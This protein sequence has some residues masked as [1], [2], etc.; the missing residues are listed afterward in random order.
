M[1][2]QIF[3]SYRR[4]G[5]DSI[6]FLLKEHLQ[7]AGYSVFIDLESLRSG[8]FDEKLFNMIEECSVVL[9]VLS[10]NVFERCDDPDDWVRK[11]IAYAIKKKKC[12]IPVMWSDEFEWPPSLPG[13]IKDVTSYNGLPVN[14]IYFDGFIEK[15]CK[16]IDS[17]EIFPTEQI[18]KLKHIVIWAD[19]EENYLHK[20]IKRMDLHE[21]Y[22]VD[23]VNEPAYLLSQNSF[24]IDSIVLIDT[25]VTKLANTD[26]MI[27]RINKYLENYVYCG[28]KLIVTHDVI[29]RRTRNIK[30]QE[31][32]YCR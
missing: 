32:N 4:S 16:M 25:D 2:Y 21:E 26:A 30:L 15:L 31:M 27:N 8:K 9:L 22:F 17:V 20:I 19:F 24:L 1:K 29:Y 23:V 6:A 11:E 28:G 3:I 10:P 18:K 14:Y 12:I 5:G 13:D 7:K